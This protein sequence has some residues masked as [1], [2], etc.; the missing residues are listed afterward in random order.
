MRNIRLAVAGMTL[1]LA[2]IVAT[3]ALAQPH[4]RTAEP[5]KIALSNSFIG[6]SGGSRWRTCSSRRA[7][8]RR[9]RAGR[10]LGLQRRQRRVDPVPADLQPDLPGRRRHRHRRR[11]DQRPERRGPAGLRPRH[12]GRVVRQHGRREVRPDRQHRPGQVRPAAGPVHRR[13]AQGPGQRRHGHRRGRHR[14]RQR[15]QQGRHGRLPANPG[16][17]VVATYSGMWDS[18]TAQRATRPSCRACRRWTGS[19]CPAAPTAW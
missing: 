11:V 18:A 4:A 13:P 9:T 2:A 6:N 1:A 3:T 19:G 17:K 8:C 10:L 7:R 14:S 12:R 5:L 15:P 16:I